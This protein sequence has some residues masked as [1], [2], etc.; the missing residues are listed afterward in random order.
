MSALVFM[1]LALV[2]LIALAAVVGLLHPPARQ[3]LAGAID[4]TLLAFAVPFEIGATA[5]GF[6]ATRLW[7]IARD[8]IEAQFYYADPESA[9][10]PWRGWGPIASVFVTVLAVTIII[11]DI[12]IFQHRMAPLLGINLPQDPSIVY[13]SA[14]IWAASLV[15]QSGTLFD[16]WGITP[17]GLPWSNVKSTWALRALMAA[18][19]ASIVI[20]LIIGA[21][22]FA[23]GQQLIHDHPNETTEAVFMAGFALLVNVALV[24]AAPSAVPSLTAAFGV[25][26]V[27]G[28]V[29]AGLAST[30]LAA[31]E[32]CIAYIAEIPAA[33][34]G[35]AGASRV[36]PWSG[37]RHAGVS[38]ELGFRG[39]PWLRD[40]SMES[41]EHALAAEEALLMPGILRTNFFGGRGALATYC[42]PLAGPNPLIVGKALFAR[43]RPLPTLSADGVLDLS[44]TAQ[45]VAETVAAVG[46]QNKAL[47]QLRGE[48]VEQLLPH[49]DLVKQ[50]FWVEQLPIADPAWTSALLRELSDRRPGMGIAVITALPEADQRVP[51]RFVS[52]DAFTQLRA[53]GVVNALFVLDQLS[54]FAERFDPRVQLRAATNVISGILAAHAQD[55]AA[56]S[57][58][59]IGALGDL[60]F[61]FASKPTGAGKRGL[62]ARTFRKGGFGN[63]GEMVSQ[64]AAAAEEAAHEPTALGFA[65]TAVDLSR[66]VFC[67]VNLPISA[68]DQRWPDV[69]AQVRPEIT[70]RLSTNAVVIAAAF[71]GLRLPDVVGEFVTSVG[72]LFPIAVEDEGDGRRNGSRTTGRGTT[73]VLA[74]G[75]AQ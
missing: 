41:A 34:L 36:P 15:I 20:T 46:N 66:P 13:R 19:I 56:P 28:A 58:G 23:Y 47:E 60:A 75:G 64:A 16:L 72:I 51:G 74:K 59:R 11:E 55:P 3:P 21:L 27:F 67:V 54:P 7:A 9:I 35:H 39:N 61:A 32:R 6:V 71:P 57:V 48:W 65:A 30:M 73:R 8:A 42:L 5:L 53:E 33:V 69:E 63:V 12:P 45:H 22:F 17:F 37:R 24:W 50:F 10:S 38:S 43:E 1:P 25:I 44:L 62:L 40:R 52:A 68:H 2:L 26:C 70:S 29:V 14:V 31:A 49:L 4:A 18:L